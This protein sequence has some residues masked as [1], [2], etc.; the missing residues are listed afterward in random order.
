MAD[1][2]LQRAIKFAGNYDELQIQNKTITNI[3]RKRKYEYV[4]HIN[5]IGNSR[6]KA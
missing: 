5:V 1:I 3:L 2:K 4:L 6:Q